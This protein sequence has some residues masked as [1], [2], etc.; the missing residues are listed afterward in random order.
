MRTCIFC[1]IV[2]GDAPASVVHR[3]EVCSAFLDTRPVNPGHV[4]IVPNEH[5][6]YL[7]DLPAE[8]GAHMFR[9]AMRM[10]EAIRRSEVPSQGLN[11][12]LAD[13][14]V[15]FQTVFHVHL[16]VVPRVK[17]DGFGLTFGPSYL[18]PPTREALEETAAAIRRSLE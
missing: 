12:F 8:T 18:S 1:R 10:A 16:H 3:D 11:L 4:L 15:A 9:I 17:G 5:A 6:A 14:A 13:G 2:A 7:A